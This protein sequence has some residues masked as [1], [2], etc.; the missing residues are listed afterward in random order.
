MVR[1]REGSRRLSGRRGVR[2]LRIVE[3]E[4]VGLVVLAVPVL[5][6]PVLI[7]ASTGGYPLLDLLLEVQLVA[8][9]WVLFDWVVQRVE[10]VRPVPLALQC[11]FFAGLLASV[12]AFVFAPQ[13]YFE[14]GSG[15]AFGA[16]L[17][18]SWQQL[19]LELTGLLFACVQVAVL[20]FGGSLPVVALLRLARRR[21]VR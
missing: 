18:D 2:W 7:G 9:L 12:V 16:S 1:A 13:S 14:F 20:A 17:Q 21:V 11:L 6:P 10:F 15:L 19:R 5:L 3:G 8:L 4:L